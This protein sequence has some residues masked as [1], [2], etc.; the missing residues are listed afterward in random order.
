MQEENKGI[1]NQ[2]STSNLV[3]EKETIKN[4]IFDAIDHVINNS[5]LELQNKG[6]LLTGSESI[7]A[8]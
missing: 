5:E 7:D 1:S 8:R 4:S 3:N 2:S 6:A